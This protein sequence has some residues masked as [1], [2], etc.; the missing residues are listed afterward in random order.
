MS[1]LDTASGDVIG[2]DQR[3]DGPTVVFIAGAGPYR[4]I[5][6][7]TTE[8][9]ELAAAAGTRTV[10]Y[11]RIGRGE[12]VA[13]AGDITLQRELEAVAALIDHAGAPAVLV[14]HSSGCSIALAAAHAGLPVAGL[15]LF[16]SPTGQASGGTEAWANE[17][18]GAL[19][20]GDG[21]RAQ[22]IY[23]RDMPPEWLEGAKA[24]P[25][26][27]WIVAATPT[28]RADAESLR[29]AVDHEALA[30]ITVPTIA[31][32][33]EQTFPGMQDS[34]EELARVMPDA[35]AITVPGAHHEWEP[36]DFAERIVRFVTR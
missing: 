13:A 22:E 21:E 15:L 35:R 30:A 9:A 26:W 12:S 17:F 19:D 6:P 29:W 14:G 32:V 36:Q 16:E 4:A 33:G 7:G 8:T 24:S 11:D 25:E 3:G 28:L 5:D 34:A 10:V 23:M 31:A 20:A 18:L 1:T 27:Q 2:F